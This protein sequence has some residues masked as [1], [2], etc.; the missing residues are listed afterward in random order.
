MYLVARTGYHY[1]LEVGLVHGEPISNKTNQHK[2]NKQ[3]KKKI[4]T[5]KPV[6]RVE[7]VGSSPDSWLTHS[8]SFLEKL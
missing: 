2:T 3:T 7:N 8:V 4:K 6:K 1:K 5:S